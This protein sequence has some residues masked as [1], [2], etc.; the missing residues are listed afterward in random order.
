MADSLLA[1]LP[2]DSSLTGT[3][4][5]YVNDGGE[6]KKITISQIWAGDSFNGGT[7]SGPI[8]DMALRQ[9]SYAQ[10][11]ASSQLDGEPVLTTPGNTFGAGELFV[12]GGGV[13]NAR[14]ISG[15]RAINSAFVIV[16]PSASATDNAAR[17]QAAVTYAYTMTPHG[18]A[19]SA[20]NYA[21]VIVPPGI[22]DFSTSFLNL[23]S[24]SPG[25]FVAIVGLTPFRDSQVITSA[26]ASDSSGTLVENAGGIRISNIT[27]R[28]T[29]TTN[30]AAAALRPCALKNFGG[31][32][33]SYENCSFVGPAS[34]A[35]GWAMKPTGTTLSTFRNCISTA[36]GF[37]G[38]EGLFGGNAYD[39]IAGDDSFGSSL[40]GGSASNFLI[41]CTAG[42]RSFGPYGIYAGVGLLTTIE[43]CTSGGSSFASLGTIDPEEPSALITRARLRFCRITA[44]VYGTDLLDDA[45][46]V[47]C[48]SATD[49]LINL[50]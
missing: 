35:N 47:Q 24:A 41:R 15:L 30:T 33:S 26:I 29:N 38:V 39:C 21:F 45:K 20:S 9:G 17:L 13:G 27:I 40:T 49:A 5:L 28:N 6:D 43:Q 8:D 7:L 1:D 2:A 14:I 44:G 32:T 19:R 50:P 36:G 4:E 46:L 31:V 48:L 18:I 10:L 23:P 3:E 25:A 42:A 16:Q 37:A 12:G 22:Y 11:L 34:S